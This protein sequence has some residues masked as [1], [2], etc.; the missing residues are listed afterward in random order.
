MV[1]IHTSSMIDTPIEALWARIRDFNALPQWYPGIMDSRIEDQLP[2][3]RIGC[4]RNFHA[5]DGSLFRERLLTL[6]DQDHTCVYEMLESPMGVTN[7][8]AQLKLTAVADGNRSLAEWSAQF[9]CAPDSTV[10][11]KHTIEGVFQAGF[12]ALK[13]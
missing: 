9:N 12:E 4:I 11:L 5:S 10:E 1:R 13:A 2:A 6:S 7:Y 3:D 8:V